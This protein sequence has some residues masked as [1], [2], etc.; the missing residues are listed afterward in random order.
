MKKGIAA[1]LALAFVAAPAM[2]DI[3]KWTD[4]SGTVHYSDTAPDGVN[5]E[6][7][8]V[9]QT[10]VANTSEMNTSTWRYNGGSSGTDM[11]TPVMTVTQPANDSVIRDNSG[12]VTVAGQVS[13]LPG[14][15]SAELLMDGNVVATGRES[16]YAN[17]QNVD[18]GTHTLIIRVKAAGGKTFESA[19][20]Q[21]TL[22]RFHK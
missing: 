22:Q 8:D 3:H 20:S 13:N 6:R 10:N 2:G 17:L 12:N 18:R 19:P 7:I 4:S 5:A 15:A 16:L 9:Q 14:A 1:I 21:F 11:G